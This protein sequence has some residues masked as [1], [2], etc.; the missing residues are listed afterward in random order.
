MTT[1]ASTV[2]GGEPNVAI[3][4]ADHVLDTGFGALVLDE[5]LYRPSW[6]ALRNH[7]PP[8]VVA[9]LRLFVPYPP[10]IRPG[11]PRPFVRWHRELDRSLAGDLVRT[12][13]GAADSV[14]ARH[15][16]A[17]LVHL[18]LTSNPTL[19]ALERNR[20]LDVYLR[21]I[22]AALD[23]ADRYGV[24]VCIAASD[25]KDE[26]PG[27]AEIE[28]CANEFRGAPLA[29]WLDAARILP[30]ERIA[31]V[32]PET[33]AEA[34]PAPV[35]GR[36]GSHLSAAALCAAFRHLPLFGIAIHDSRDGN[37]GLLPG[38]G[39]VDWG[40]LDSLIRSAPLW[41]LDLAPDSPGELWGRARAFFDEYEAA[42]KPPGPGGIL[43]P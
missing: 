23:A 22:E 26:F 11:S 6:D 43:A 40:A 10:S 3:S 36:D 7:L 32:R 13:F 33:H 41:C 12:T 1:F 31:P 38:T 28:I 18:D 25:R 42:D 17:P 5:P 34:P 9:A 37:D 19:S 20:V 14:S 27:S 39:T 2:R 24:T 16:I 35:G 8:G 29:L 21:L 4:R 30:P 15:V